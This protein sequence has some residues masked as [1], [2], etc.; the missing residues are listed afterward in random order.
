MITKTERGELRS[1]VRQQMKV[2]RSEVRQRESELL[3]D[4]EASIA[5]QY[6][7]ADTSEKA[8]YEKIDQIVRE[9]NQSIGEVV[10]DVGGEDWRVHN[11]LIPPRLSRS[12]QRHRESLRQA[13]LSHLKSKV[14]VATLHLDRTEADL[15]RQLSLDAL[16]SEAAREFLVSILSVSELVPAIRLAELEAALEDPTGQRY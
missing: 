4:I 11:Y 12:D 14:Q 10:A 6:A 1:V 8:M 16:E 3:A 2:L 9:A 7:E 15:L 5:D 13:A